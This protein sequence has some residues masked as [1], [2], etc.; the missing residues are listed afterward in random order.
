MQ[1]YG[2]EDEDKEAEGQEKLLTC[3]RR[4]SMILSFCLIC[5]SRYS[6]LLQDEHRKLDESE[7]PPR[8][9]DEE[10]RDNEGVIGR[11]G[12]RERER[13]VSVV[14]GHKC[15]AREG[16]AGYSKIRSKTSAAMR[17]AQKTREGNWSE[18]YG[19]EGGNRKQDR[20]FI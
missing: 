14:M 19:G 17:K 20:C 8:E 1:L 3:L 9:D 15:T 4:D 6:R 16:G 18:L 7:E 13:V 2:Y 5:A 11:K 10:D 12:E